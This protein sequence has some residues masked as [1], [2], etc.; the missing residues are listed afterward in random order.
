MSQQ[1]YDPNYQ[2]Y[3][4]PNYQQYYSQNTQYNQYYDQSGDYNPNT[5]FNQNNTSFYDTIGSIDYQSF[6]KKITDISEV[7]TEAVN[8]G[9][10]YLSQASE[11]SNR[12]AELLRKKNDPNYNK[13]YWAAEAGIE[14]I[15]S[16]GS[17][18]NLI[19]DA[20]SFGYEK[21]YNKLLGPQQK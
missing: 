18:A 4:D 2:Q 20:A 1:Y 9:Q 10:N 12:W 15:S 19:G 6:S 13:Y 16:L 3:Y 14:T 7:S 17:V 5:D 8:K 21:V 11:L